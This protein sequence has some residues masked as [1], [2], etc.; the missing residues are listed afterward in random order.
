MEAALTVI[1][2]NCHMLYWGGR[3]GLGSDRYEELSCLRHLVVLSSLLSLRSGVIQ[4]KG[5]A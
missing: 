1:H 2:D 5:V 4:S 3:S